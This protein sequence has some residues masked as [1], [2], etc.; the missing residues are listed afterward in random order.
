MPTVIIGRNGDQP[1]KITDSFVSSRHAELIINSPSDMW[2]VDTNSSNGTFF[3]ENGVFKR[4]VPNKRY[5]VTPDTFVRFGEHTQ[6]HVRRL[7]PEEEK[8]DIC[9]LRTISDHYNN[10]KL[11]LQSAQQSV[12]GLRGLQ[13]MFLL[14][15]TLVTTI[16]TSLLPSDEDI[17]I[18]LIP[19][20]CALVLVA[21][22]ILVLNAY[23][24]NKSRTIMEAQKH[25]ED[26]YVVRYVCPKCRHSFRGHHYENILSSGSCPRCHVKYI[27]STL[28]Q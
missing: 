17:I 19:G 1:V 2:L 24:R 14:G 20:I 8:I 11:E 21:V 28:P 27:D 16:V 6:M 13:A 15:G 7:I 12:Q 22:G 5:R 23:I 25:N 4:L 10:T 9:G 3:F 18:K 26:T